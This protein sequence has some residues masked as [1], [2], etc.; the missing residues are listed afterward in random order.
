MRRNHMAEIRGLELIIK[1]TNVNL[2]DHEEIQ[3]GGSVA[4]ELPPVDFLF[5]VL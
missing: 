4:I 5:D 3:V 1:R 2:I